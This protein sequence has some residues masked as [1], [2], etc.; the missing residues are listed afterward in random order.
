MLALVLPFPL[1]EL[2][3]RCAGLTSPCRF[4]PLASGTM[5]SRVKLMGWLVGSCMSMVL[6]QSQQTACS[7][8]RSRRCRSRVTVFFQ[9]RESM[10]WLCLGMGVILFPRG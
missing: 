4:P 5:W 8:W 3:L 2:Q 7:G 9:R 6:P 1:A 10:R